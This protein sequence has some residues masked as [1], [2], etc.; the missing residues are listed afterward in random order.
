MNSY[1]VWLGRILGSLLTLILALLIV[2][3]AGNVF[4]RFVLGMSLSWGE[5]AAKI[6]LTYLTFLGAAYAMKDN[7]H[8]SFDYLVH[9]LPE[10]PRRCLRCFRWIAILTMS[11]LLLFWS[12]QVTWMIREWTMPSTGISRSLVYG[13]APVSMVFMISYSLRSLKS[14]M[15][16]FNTDADQR[17]DPS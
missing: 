16:G 1:F 11:V 5:E 9:H 17:K 10:R 15:Q 14:D 6:L 2:I 13:V 3:V 8:Y 12:G 4:C 7:S